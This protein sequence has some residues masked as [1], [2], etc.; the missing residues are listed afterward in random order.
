MLLAHQYVGHC[1]KLFFFT[2][3]HLWRMFC[4]LLMVTGQTEG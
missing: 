3:Q 1:T 2:S 4:F